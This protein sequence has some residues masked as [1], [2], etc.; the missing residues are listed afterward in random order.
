MS[1]ATPTRVTPAEYLAFERASELKH[2]LRDGEI[3]PMVGAKRPHNEISANAILMVRGAFRGRNCRAYGPDMRVKANGN[4]T[5]PDLS[6]LC[7]TGEFEDDEDDTLLNPS[8]LFEVLSPSTELYDRGEKFEHYRQI[9]SLTDYLLIAQDRVHVEHYRRQPDGSWNLR[10]YRA[11][12]DVVRL[13]SLGCD[14][15]LRDLYD[16]VWND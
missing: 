8:A 6:A 12:E 7:G 3:V 1:T 2:E 5:Y 13:E 11:L 10:E 4:Y 16:K 9:P 15:P 14:L